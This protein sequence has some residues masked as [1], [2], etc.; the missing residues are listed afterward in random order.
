MS[1]YII[2]V[3]TLSLT[4]QLALAN[5]LFDDSNSSYNKP[6]VK[7]TKR[8]T[9]I[10]SKVKN[11]TYE[12]VVYVPETNGDTSVVDYSNMF[13][14]NS[15]RVVLL[16][17]TIIIARLDYEINS[18]ERNIP[19]QATVAKEVFSNTGIKAFSI[20]DY[21]QGSIV[22]N[23]YGS[24]VSIVMTPRTI[25]AKTIGEEVELRKATAQLINK[26][27]GNANVEKI[28][29]NEQAGSAVL[30]DIWN[31]SAYGNTG[32]KSEQLAKDFFN[33]GSGKRRTIVRIKKGNLILIRT[34]ER[35][36][37]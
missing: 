37:Y 9:P 29:S 33:V 8:N 5:E 30:T 13:D 22:V 24:D 7:S 35:V 27:N 12:D 20:G 1:K 15:N 34:N 32:L 23:R 3:L 4:F 31:T 28:I 19:F 36:E 16:S 26:D 21:I 14:N 25:T 6:T 11:L 18:E 10:R 2:F 17:D